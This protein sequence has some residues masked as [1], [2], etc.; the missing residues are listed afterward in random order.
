VISPEKFSN[1]HA[2]N[3]L[4]I[5]REESVVPLFAMLQVLASEHWTAAQCALPHSLSI[6]RETKIARNYAN[7]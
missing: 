5:F 6:T 1:I 3:V 4:Q 2:L 7:S